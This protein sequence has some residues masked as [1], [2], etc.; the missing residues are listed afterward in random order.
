MNKREIVVLTCVLAAGSVCAGLYCQ[1]PDA[2]HAWAIHDRNRPNPVKVEAP[3]GRP[4][5]DAVV[6]FDGTRASADRNWYTGRDGTCRWEVVEGALRCAPK[7]GNAVT[8]RVFADCQLHLEWKTPKPATGWGQGRGNSGVILFGGY[9]IQVLDSYLTDPSKTPNPNPNYADGQAGAVYAQNPPL[10]NPARPEGA[11]QSYDIVF[12][13]P[14]WDGDTLVKGPTVTLFFNGVLVQDNWEFEGSTYNLERKPVQKGAARY[15]IQLQDHGTPVAYR[16][17]WVREIP[18]V[19]ANTVQGGPGVKAA[20]VLALRE[21]TAA[22][23]FARLAPDAADVPALDA[24]LEILAYSKDAKYVARYDR[25][26]AA[27]VASTASWDDAALRRHEGLVRA[28]EK[29]CG[30]LVKYG[31]LAAD[32]AF[33]RRVRALAARLSHIKASTKHD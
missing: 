32:D 26:A 12:H 30:L 6:L 7:T 23:L 4:P 13:A 17:I 11:W 5:S 2:R 22:R 33:V 15:P 28:F 10:V 19:Y 9:E 21:K 31:T 25:A 3:E 27:F 1:G 14:V 18:S 24:L 29:S 20:D 8:R 16:N